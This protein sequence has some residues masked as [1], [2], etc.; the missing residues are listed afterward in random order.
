MNDNATPRSTLM[1]ES[2]RMKEPTI[3]TGSIYDCYNPLLP[4]FGK[5]SSKIIH[6]KITYPY[7]KPQLRLQGMTVPS[8]T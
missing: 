5:N 4:K 7:D 2:G 6:S 1:V 8:R 3:A